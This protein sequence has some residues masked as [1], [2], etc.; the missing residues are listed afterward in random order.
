VDELMESIG[1]RYFTK[2]DFKSGYHHIRIHQGDEYKTT[3]KTK[4]D[5]FQD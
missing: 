1:A 5:L 4:E 2:I 3:F